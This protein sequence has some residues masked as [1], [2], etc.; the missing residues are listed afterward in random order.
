MQQVHLDPKDPTVQQLAKLAFP[1][2]NGRKFLAYVT[3]K[4]TFSGT[5]WESGRRSQYRLI[6]IADMQVVDIETAPFLRK[7]D[8]HSLPHT[9]P[10]GM[11]V[12]EYVQAGMRSY[13]IF[14]SPTANITPA[15]K[16]DVVLTDDEKTVL[17]ATRS[18]KASYANIKEFRF[19]EA[20][21]KRGI[22]WERWVAAKSSLMEKKLLNRAGAI[23]IDGRNLIGFEQL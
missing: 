5:M 21:Q 22:T 1:D 13:M 16:Q 9:I 19:T 12:V 14:H 17:I 20:N 7:S 8:F 6:R 3:D 23:T 15:I 10:D 18:L 11:I 4:V 2:Y